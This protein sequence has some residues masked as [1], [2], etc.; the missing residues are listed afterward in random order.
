MSLRNAPKHTQTPGVR[1][2]KIM[3]KMVQEES[4]IAGSMCVRT[5]QCIRISTCVHVHAYQGIHLS[6][7]IH[8]DMQVRTGV[9]SLCVCM[10]ASACVRACV[11]CVCVSLFM[12]S[13]SQECIKNA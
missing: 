11:P 2:A 9:A 13:Q 1:A 6:K 7:R 3:S 5:S 10:P 4:A 12:S 8:V